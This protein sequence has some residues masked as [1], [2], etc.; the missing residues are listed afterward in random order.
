[1]VNAKSPS[2]SPVDK[3]FTNLQIHEYLT[4]LCLRGSVTKT[5]NLRDSLIPNASP[6]VVKS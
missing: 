2:L 3:K 6:E 4:L 1:M 5:E